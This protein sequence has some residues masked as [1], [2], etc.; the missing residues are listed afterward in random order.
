LAIR[1]LA[2]IGE[3]PAGKLFLFNGLTLEWRTIGQPK[4]PGCKTCG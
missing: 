2:R 4:D 1:S 3:D